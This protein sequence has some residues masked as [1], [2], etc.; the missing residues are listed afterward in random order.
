MVSADIKCGK[1]IAASF[2]PKKV[3]FAQAKESLNR[4]YR[5]HEIPLSEQGSKTAIW[6]IR[7][8]KKKFSVSLVRED[9]SY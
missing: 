2:Y 6:R 4:L 9:E 7:I 5:G 3:S 1:Y 8:E